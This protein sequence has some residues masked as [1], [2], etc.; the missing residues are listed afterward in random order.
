[1]FIAGSIIIEYGMHRITINKTR[2][3]HYIIIM[4]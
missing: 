2:I 1:M 4:L 3:V